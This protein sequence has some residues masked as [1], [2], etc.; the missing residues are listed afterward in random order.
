[1]LSVMN[2]QGWNVTRSK[3]FPNRT[4][5]VNGRVAAPIRMYLRYTSPLTSAPASG[6]ASNHSS[7]AADSATVRRKSSEDE[8]MRMRAARSGSR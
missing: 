3:S 6:A 7:A 8:A 5:S 4:T 1:M 2:F